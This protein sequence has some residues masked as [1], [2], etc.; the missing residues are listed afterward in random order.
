[1]PR[2]T[3]PRGPCPWAANRSRA[4]RRLPSDLYREATLPGKVPLTSG[5]NTFRITCAD[6]ATLRLRTVALTGPNGARIE[7]EAARFDGHGPGA[8]TTGSFMGR[9]TAGGQVIEY[10]AFTLPN[11][12]INVGTYYPVTP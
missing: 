10:R 9:V 1:M 6:D 7:L 11:G 4:S 8:S 3:T 12:T 2:S 5:P